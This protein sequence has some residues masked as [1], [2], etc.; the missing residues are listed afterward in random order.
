M[1]GIIGD[2]SGITGNVTGILGDVSGIT[3]NVT[4]IFGE[5]SGISGDIDGC[6][7]TYDERKAG[8]EIKDLIGEL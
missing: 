3:G 4:G 8:V 5:A 1:S 7:I 2:V 6:K